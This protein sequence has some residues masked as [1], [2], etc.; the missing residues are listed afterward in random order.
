MGEEGGQ[1]GYNTPLEQTASWVC[2]GASAPPTQSVSHPP[3]HAAEHLTH[4]HTFSDISKQREPV[5]TELF[6]ASKTKRHQK[7]ENW[8]LRFVSRPLANISASI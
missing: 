4:T 3:T 8:L 1:P 6:F 5:I 7:Q 2:D